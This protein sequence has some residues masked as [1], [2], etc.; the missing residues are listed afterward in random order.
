[1]HSYKNINTG[2]IFWFEFPYIKS[3]S[4]ISEKNT[5][6][7]AIDELKKSVKKLNILIVDDS[8][9]VVKILTKKLEFQGHKVIMHYISRS[10]MSF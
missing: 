8:S 1:M 2:S 3:V 9:T 7:N 10:F 4:I 5:V 6:K